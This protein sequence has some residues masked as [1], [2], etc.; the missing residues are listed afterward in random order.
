M[1]KISIIVPVYKK[2][3][4][5]DY[6]LKSI[7][8]QSF[9][10]FELILVDDGS[11][12]NCGKICDDYAKKDNRIKVIHI[13]NGGVSNARNVGLENASGQYVTFVDADDKLTENALSEL[14]SSVNKYNADIVVGGMEYELTN[15][16]ANQVTVN[17]QLNR[18]EKLFTATEFS[19][20]L[21]NIWLNNN[22]KSIW[23]KLYDLSIINNNSLRF[24]TNLIVLEDA[25]FVVEY[26]RYCNT[27]LSIRNIVYRVCDYVG[28]DSAMNRSRRDYADD[29]KYVQ[30]KMTEFFDNC[31]VSKDKKCRD[32][33]YDEF[34]WAWKNLWVLPAKTFKEKKKK[35]KRMKEVLSWDEMQRFVLMNKKEYTRIEYIFMRIKNI[36]G[37]RL[38][39]KFRKIIYNKVKKLSRRYTL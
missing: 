30:N 13:S 21:D 17:Y 26:L 4:S 25:D 16:G 15:Y 12:D 14:E 37:I 34:C 18:E 35:Y 22:M 28:R 8:S 3:Y 19:E 7:L 10:D 9:T 5:I 11:P 23:S 39:Q 32:V 20:I 29:V 36:T 1:P 24:N 31:G 6:C 33:L 27:V 2:E 38:I